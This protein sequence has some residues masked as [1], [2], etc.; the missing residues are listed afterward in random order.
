MKSC[1]TCNRTYAD[2]TLTFC[3]VDGSILS[4]PYE[5]QTKKLYQPRETEPPPTEILHSTYK[6][7]NTIP[8]SQLQPT[9]Q[10][11]PQIYA[12]DSTQGQPMKKG[13]GKRW[14]AVGSAVFVLAIVGVIIALSQKA[15]FT[16]DDS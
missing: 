14:L 13:V 7:A 3:L 4:A 6:P 2:D 8:S 15:R 5:P 11:S 1:P 9:M 16:A 12:A 10:I